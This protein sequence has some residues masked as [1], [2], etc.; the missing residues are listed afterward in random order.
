MP[1]AL[2]IPTKNEKDFLPGPGQG[3]IQCLESEASE[4]VYLPPLSWTPLSLPAIFSNMHLISPVFQTL[5][6]GFLVECDNLHSVFQRK[7]R[8]VS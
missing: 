1:S 5:R 8:I 3:L 6:K 7:A 4:F 2:R